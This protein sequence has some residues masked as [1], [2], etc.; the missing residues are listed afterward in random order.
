MQPTICRFVVAG[1]MLA[2]AIIGHFLY[3]AVFADAGHQ[4]ILAATVLA[5]G[6][7]QMLEGFRP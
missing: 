4:P 6:V 3:R 5:V 2:N 1:A 7:A